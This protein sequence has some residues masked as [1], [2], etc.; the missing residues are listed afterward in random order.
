M[1]VRYLQCTYDAAV[2]FSSSGDFQADTIKTDTHFFRLGLLLNKEK[3]ELM[4]RPTGLK[5]AAVTIDGSQPPLMSD[6]LC[7][8]NIISNSLSLHQ[9]KTIRKFAPAPRLISS[10]NES[11]LI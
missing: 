11:T 4:H 2:L 1:K 10:K 5:Q 9:E 6:I 8:G 7:H 3:T